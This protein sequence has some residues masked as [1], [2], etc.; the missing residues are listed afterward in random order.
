MKRKIIHI[1]EDRCNGCAACIPNCPEGALQIIDGKA[2]L[3]SDLFCDGLGACLGHCPEG[4]ILVEEREAEPY[5]ER[6]VM[7]NIVRQGAGTI[8]AHLIHLQ[9]HG[10]DALYRQA[11]AY[12]REQG[13]GNPCEDP[14][15]SRAEHGGC[16]GSR[17]RTLKP[18]GA[19]P[20]APS[21][22]RPSQL[23]N[24]PI[25]IHLA[26]P[27]APY[28]RGA[29]LL[30]AADCAGFAAT[31]LHNQWLA[32]RVTL[33]GCPKL[34]DTE[35]YLEKLTAIFKQNE[36]RSLTVLHMEVP[37]CGG[38]VAL[39]REALTRSGAQTP[40]TAVQISLQGEILRSLPVA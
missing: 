12:L 29:D 14:G 7:E 18:S 33:I 2:R 21:S 25:Q 4:A 1:D 10:E 32:G 34:D 23:Q 37:C 17:L 39:A 9:E 22:E 27:R 38:L 15:P 36:P 28:F 16:P 24:W 26:N 35:A 40:F 19:A 6:R 13:I 30:L 8:R 5:D 3:V 11:A 31:D 20:A